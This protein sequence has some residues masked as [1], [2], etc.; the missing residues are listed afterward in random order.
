MDQPPATPTLSIVIVS[1]NVAD[2]LMGCLRSIAAAC[3]A[4]TEVIVVDSASSDDTV[5]RVR[6][7]YPGV[8]L[9]PQ[10]ANVG[11][12][13]GTNIGLTAAH[14]EFLMLLNPDTELLDGAAY[15]MVAAL[16]DNP[17]IGIVGPRTLNPDGSGQSTRRRFPAFSTAVFEST[18]LQPFAPRGLL[19]TY[20]VRDVADDATAPVDWVQGSCLLARREVYAAIGGL[21]EG[22]VMYSEELDWCRRAKD[23]GWGV[24]YL[25]SARIIHYG[26]QSSAQVPARTHILFN[27]SKLRY[28]RKYHGR[29]A[30]QTLRLILLANFALQLALEWVKGLLGH[31]RA[32][33]RERV[34]TYWHVLRSGLKVS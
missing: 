3:P 4:D 21:D 29:A 1:W 8:M 25:G 7:G 33:R 17:A 6:A 15:A 16:R 20:F 11:F 23:A 26:G 12:T 27:Q 30:A 9:L 10:S 22:F 14:G 28:M 32:L 2:L 31:K 18:W 34:S 24:L 5:A 19:D 13:K